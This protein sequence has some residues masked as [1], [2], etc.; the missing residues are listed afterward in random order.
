M[1]LVTSGIS[2][3][4]LRR[5]FI[6]LLMDIPNERSSHTRPTPRGG[7]LGFI[8]AFAVAMALA[9]RYAPG[10]LVGTIAPQTW[11]ALVPLA[12][13][14]V[15]DDWRNLPSAV[16]Y[17][18]QLGT[19]WYVV[20]GY[21]AFTFPWLDQLGSLAGPLAFV[22]SVICFTA[23]INFYNFMD[24]LD[25]LV[26]G[27]S[28]VQLAFLA[29]WC[30]QPVLWL[31]VAA[32]VGFLFWNWSPAKIF[33]G[34]A[35]STI[36]GAVVATALMTQPNSF[37]QSW[38]SVAILLP[39]IGDAVYTLA[40]RLSRGENIFQAHRSHIYQRLHQAGWPHGQVAGLYI[41]ATLAIAF[42]LWQFGTGAAWVSL[43]ATLLALVAGELY[44][45]LSPK[46]NTYIAPRLASED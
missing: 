16:R 13:I 21:G 41:G 34:D 37:E 38:A 4:M 10:L 27:V 18:V 26:A 33:M 2:V 5:F 23:L 3:G 43:G 8:M 11:L 9:Q 44:L 17:L 36:L 19:A 12:L 35:G 22:I 1:A 30:Q 15:I 20:S 42:G 7:G 25:G 40:R 45:S 6:G 39:L 31:W 46:V 24:G 29:L 14:G 32:L 28:A